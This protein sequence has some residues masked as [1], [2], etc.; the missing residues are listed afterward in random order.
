[1]AYKVLQSF[2]DEQSRVVYKPG[3]IYP[4]DSPAERIEK[5]INLS[6]IIEILEEVETIT[7]KNTVDE[8]KAFLD[9]KNIKYAAKATK[10][11]LL[12]LLED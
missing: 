8:I 3:S 7:D 6:F 5:L 12:A 9:A 2:R 11:E 4:T 10:S 1:M